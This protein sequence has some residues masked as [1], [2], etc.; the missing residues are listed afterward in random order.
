MTMS[1]DTARTGRDRIK[2]AYNAPPETPRE[3]MWSAIS[4]KIAALEAS[5]PPAEGRTWHGGERDEAAAGATVD[6]E[7]F[8]A[9][10]DAIARKPGSATLRRVGG[11]AVAAAALLVLGVGIGRMTAPTGPV[12][13]EPTP[14]AR[15][16]W[17]DGGAGLGLA[18]REHLD[19]TESLLTMVRADARDGQLDPGVAAWAEELLVQTRLLLDRPAGV[20][21]ET[22]DLLMDLELVLAQVVGVAETGPGDDAR[23]RTE[24]ELTLKSLDQGEVLPRIQAALPMMSGA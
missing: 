19:R 4:A 16:T 20:A 21:P 3:Q 14:I 18:A 8:R 7:A 22:R 2:E 23:A 6:L 11:W 13:N 10:R 9:R 12:A 1:D 24:M 17:T 5:A 15:P